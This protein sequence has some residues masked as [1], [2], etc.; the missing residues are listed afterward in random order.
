MELSNM[1]MFIG[2][3]VVIVLFVVAIV[4]IIKEKELRAIE[5]LK[6][7]LAQ[8]EVNEKVAIKEREM[9]FQESRRVV[10][11]DKARTERNERMNTSIH[12]GVGNG[13]VG[14]FT[15]EPIVK[16]TVSKTQFRPQS[17]PSRP[18][19]ARNTY[20]SRSSSN[21]SYSGYYDGNDYSNNNNDNDSCYSSNS[22]SSYDS[23]SSS[24][25]DSGS[26]DSGGSCSFD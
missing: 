23:S 1:E 3:I 18:Q 12:G 14:S 26:S 21:T 22:S 8:A 24:S 13:K 10:D 17:K 15:S 19:P 6:F 5:K 11:V 4:V 25:Y 16:P 7:E 9:K 20:Q 2:L